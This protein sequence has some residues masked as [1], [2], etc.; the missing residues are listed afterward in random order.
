[1]VPL[2]GRPA[3][4]F[5]IRPDGSIDDSYQLVSLYGRPAGCFVWTTSWFLCYQMVL[6]MTL[7]SW[8]LCMSDQLVLFCLNQ[9]VYLYVRPACSIVIKPAGSC[10]R[11]TSWRDS[12][13]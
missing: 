7:P 5:V 1:M 10:V 2:Y 8:F 12:Y 4:S 6:F 3:G 11:V 13:N 9:L